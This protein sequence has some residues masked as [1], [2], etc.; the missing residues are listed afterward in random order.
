MVNE[1]L[2]DFIRDGLRKG[3][4]INYLERTLINE[5]WDINQVDEAINIVQTPPPPPSSTPPPSP[6]LTWPPTAQ[7]E[8]QA[9]SKRPATSKSSRPTGVTVICVLGFLGALVLL[10]SGIL[11]TGIGGII[12]NIG[13]PGM[14]G[15]ETASI[16]LGGFGSLLGPLLDLMGFVLIALAVIYFA[17]FYLMLK[18]EKTGFVLVIVLGLVQIIGGA[19]SFSMNSATMIVLWIIIIGYLLTK[20]KLFV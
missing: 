11:L 1:K 2:V 14:L 12:G 17:G 6:P 16:T 3:Y 9:P 4:S 13:L 5:G 8:Q 18:M 19:M 20:R 7:A 15:N 10:L